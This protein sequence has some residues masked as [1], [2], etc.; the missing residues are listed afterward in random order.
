M[1]IEVPFII[2]LLAIPL[3]F[4]WRWLLK[5]FI[6]NERNRKIATWVI[7]ICSAPILY[8]LLIILWIFIISYYPS[9][10]FNKKEWLADKETRY[11]LSEDIIE[12]QI[13]IGK[14][15]QQVREILGNDENKEEDNYWQYYLGFKPTLFA[16]DPDILRVEFKNGKVINVQQ[17]KG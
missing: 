10:D 5:K 4:F 9:Y 1:S 3:Y 15:K 6:K 7:T 11:E 8:V 13:L 12:S 17:I 2:I 14:T 16:I